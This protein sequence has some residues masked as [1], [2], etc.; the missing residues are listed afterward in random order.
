[1]DFRTIFQFRSK[2]IWWLDV[3]FYFVVSLLVA[4][5]L[6]YLVFIIKNVI[7][8]KEIASV[9]D[10]LLTVGTAEQKDQE[11]QVILY[12]AKIQDF[13]NL[14]G[15]HEFASNTFS[16]LEDETQPNVWFKQFN[17]DQKSSQVQ[18]T[19]EAEDM[20]AF[21]R[22][23][24]TFE[25]NEYVKEVGTLNSSLSEGSTINFNFSL[26]LN[27]EIFSYLTNTKNKVKIQEE[28]IVDIISS[29]LSTVKVEQEEAGEEIIEEI[30]VIEKSNEKLI[31]AFDIPLDPEVVGFIDQSTHTILLNIPEKTDITRLVPTVIISDNATVYPESNIPQD[32][33]KPVIYQV[34]AEDD[35]T[36]EYT[37]TVKFYQTEKQ[38]QEEIEKAKQ[39]S[40][41]KIFLTVA[42][43]AFLT[44][45]GLAIYLVA[46]KKGF[47]KTFRKNKK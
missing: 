33:S 27:P 34:T 30:G 16:F 45:V 2:K 3:I 18:L 20:D 40:V 17:L 39:T 6:C 13:K 46:M 47:L 28:K 25:K 7:Q 22:Q 11:I 38:I 44:T 43:V 14:I 8:K 5:I 15:D 19:G 35:S 29:S 23:T 31:F 1:M 36:Q 9:E 32:F 42:L 24:A 21:S 10:D 41:V 12:R 37:V 26:T 4:T